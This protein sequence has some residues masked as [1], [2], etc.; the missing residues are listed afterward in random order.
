[1]DPQQ[2]GPASWRWRLALTAVILGGLLVRVV[3]LGGRVLHWDEARVGYWT[4]RY[5]ETGSFSYRPVIHGPFLPLVNGWVFELVGAT[6]ASARIIVALGGAAIP[7]VV[8][9][10]RRWLPPA[11]VVGVALL[12]ATDPTLVYYS[13]FM[14]NDMLVGGATLAAV[15]LAAR[16]VDSDRAVLLVP[17]GG[18]LGAALLMKGTVLLYV[19]AAVGAG[20]LL[21]DD[22]L[23]RAPGYGGRRVRLT[24]ARTAVR[25][26]LRERGGRYLIAAVAAVVVLLAVTAWGYAPRPAVHTGPWPQRVGVAV[27]G[28]GDAVGQFVD[29]WLL[30]AR[31]EHGY[32]PYLAHLVRTLVVGSP[33]LVSLGVVGIALDR[34]RTRQRPLVAFAGWWAL[35]AVVGYP[36]ATDIKAP[37]NAVHVLLPL[38]IPAGVALAELG[39]MAYAGRRQVAAGA[40]IGCVVLT[41]VTGVGLMMQHN[42]ASVAGAPVVQWA[43]P[44]EELRDALA[45]IEV[46]TRGHDG[47]DLLYVGGEDGAYHVA[48][49]STVGTPPPGGPGWH[50][51]LPLPWYTERLD[52]HVASV[53]ADGELTSQ[54]QDPPP[55]VIAPAARAA[56]L[57]SVLPSHRAQTVPLRLWDREVVVLTAVDGPQQ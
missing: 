40:I 31:Q 9:G 1:M 45:A 20:V 7:L 14:R 19:L 51:R 23:L 42:S 15:V 25:G 56:E 34:Y 21:A 16:A 39:R 55:V 32:L 46:A 28:L 35:L 11:A 29:F 24:A 27:G 38:S 49:Q 43:Q 37:W 10:L 50:E 54:L 48:D 8:L 53:P 2:P 4:L 41:G 52:L 44:G 3:D 18:L 57:Q 30:G 33:V 6:D 13:R 12:I 17:A 22:L 5:L 26:W 36:L 47:V